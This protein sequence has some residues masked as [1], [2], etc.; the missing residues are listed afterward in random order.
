MMKAM[1]RKQ[2]LRKGGVEEKSPSQGEITWVQRARWTTSPQQHEEGSLR[3]TP[4]PRGRKAEE[5]YKQAT[6][7]SKSLQQM[8]V[9]TLRSKLTLNG[10]YSGYRGYR[11]LLSVTS[12]Q[13]PKL[14]A[15]PTPLCA[16]APRLLEKRAGL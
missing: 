10:W 2:C 1:K 8:V 3:G 6:V 7:L 15:F 14:G 13:T 4:F 16:A 12:T 5:G 11:A 9:V